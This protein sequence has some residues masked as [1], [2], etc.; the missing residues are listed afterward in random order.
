MKFRQTSTSI[1]AIATVDGE[2]GTGCK[3][4]DSMGQISLKTGR[5]TGATA[6]MLELD[7]EYKK[8]LKAKPCN[9]VTFTVEILF[10]D[11][12]KQ[13][14][15]DIVTSNVL[16]GLVWQVDGMGL[17]PDNSEAITS[18][19]TVVAENG[20]KLSKLLYDGK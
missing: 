3:V 1:K 10:T 5:F 8:L 11:E 12:I 6:C 18:K 17:A 15:V 16:D 4:G 2:N 14:E 20:T 19:I 7:K 13:H 9:K